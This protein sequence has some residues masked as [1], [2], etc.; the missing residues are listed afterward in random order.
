MPHAEL[1][2]G[3]VAERSGVATSTLRFYE[4]EGLITSRRTA[5]NQRRYQREVLRR[6]A[7]IR[8]AQRVGISL[9]MI[10]D[11]LNLLPDER[12]PTREDWA[13]L[14][15]AWEEDLTTRILLL[16]Q[17]RDSLTGCIGCG[18][19]SISRC[20]L[21]NPE[22]RLGQYGPGP[23]TLRGFQEAPSGRQNLPLAEP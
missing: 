23:R 13:N 3:E 6:V 16:Q 5:G 11:A 12:T 22:D 21:V 20:P 10:R 15:A 4:K 1:T 14:S 17:L 7:F 9:A 8:V 2:V 18:C 19:L